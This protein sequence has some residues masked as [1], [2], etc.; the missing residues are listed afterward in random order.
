MKSPRKRI[1][2]RIGKMTYSLSADDDVEQ[3][4]DIAATAD[5]MIEQVS[6]QSPG[7]NETS[8]SVLALVNAVSMMQ[9]AYEKTRI[10]YLSRDEALDAKEEVKAELSRL[11]EQFWS[12][13]KDLLYYRNL[14]DVYESKIAEMASAID[15]DFKEEAA[16]SKGRSRKR[17]VKPLEERQTTINGVGDDAEEADN[18]DTKENK[19]NGPTSLEKGR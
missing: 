11:R 12:M 5:A 14:C 19:G 7:L 9:D 17:R 10:A 4:R 15:S 13:K 1:K 8:A 6:R 18:E 2:V 3:M 16:S